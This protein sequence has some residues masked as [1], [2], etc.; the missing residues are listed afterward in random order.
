MKLIGIE[1]T[2]L[3]KAK[4]VLA[5][6]HKLQTISNEFDN[7]KIKVYDSKGNEVEDCSY[8]K[9]EYGEGWCEQVYFI[10]MKDKDLCYN[11]I[12]YVDMDDGYRS[13]AGLYQIKNKE[14]CLTKNLEVFNLNCS[15]TEN[16]SIEKK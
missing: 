16:K 5:M 14:L 12:C 1:R 4:K 8:N 10:T 13:Y 2:D 9:S 3:D 6:L 7:S 15:Y 11:W